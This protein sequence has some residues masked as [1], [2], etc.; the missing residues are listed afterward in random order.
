MD[1]FD[2]QSFESKH[3]NLILVTTIG[4]GPWKIELF[5]N[6]DDGFHYAKG[7]FSRWDSIC[8]VKLSFQDQNHRDAWIKKMS[9]LNRG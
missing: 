7:P 8:Y 5:L 1:I 2:V 4:E 3:R 9:N 6:P